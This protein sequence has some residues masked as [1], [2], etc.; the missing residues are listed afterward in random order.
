MNINN[1]IAEVRASEEGRVR[2]PISS[3]NNQDLSEALGLSKIPVR[4][5]GEVRADGRR[6]LDQSVGTS[7]LGSAATVRKSTLAKLAKREATMHHAM[8]VI[9]TN[10][11]SISVKDARRVLNVELAQHN[12]D[13]QSAVA[14]L[15]PN[16]ATADCKEPDD[17]VAW[18]LTYKRMLDGDESYETS[19]SR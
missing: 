8:D 17:M 6:L 9:K 4:K 5:V 1:L 3:M 16:L 2:Q 14:C 13:L 15:A 11:N 19:Y 12:F 10:T 18:L 7:S